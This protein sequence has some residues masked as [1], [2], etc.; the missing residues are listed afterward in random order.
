MLCLFWHTDRIYGPV[1]HGGSLHNTTHGHVQ[2][3][4]LLYRSYR[5][6]ARLRHVHGR[7][8]AWRR[9]W[10]CRLSSNNIR[11]SSDR[12]LLNGRCTR[13]FRHP[14]DP[15]FSLGPGQTVYNAA[16]CT[17]NEWSLPRKC[18]SDGPAADHTTGCCSSSGS[19]HYTA[20]LPFVSSCHDCSGCAGRSF[21]CRS[22]SHTGNNS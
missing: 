18:R 22:R 2:P 14:E 16:T 5:S 8:S 20:G 11:P 19:A 12:F 17:S 6:K 15:E 10:H 21:P 3:E 1:L 4:L 9:R 13:V 7:Y